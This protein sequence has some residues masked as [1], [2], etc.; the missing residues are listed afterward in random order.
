MRFG[1]ENGLANSGRGRDH[2]SAD[3]RKA[4]NHLSAMLPTS[5][6]QKGSL[7]VGIVQVGR[8]AMAV[9]ALWVQGRRVFQ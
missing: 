1:N 3:C 7:P 5:Q 9:L 6:R 2:S 8:G 4:A